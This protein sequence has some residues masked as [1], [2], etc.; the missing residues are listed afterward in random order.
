MRLA[1]RLVC[2]KVV[3]DQGVAPVR[4]LGRTSMASSGPAARSRRAVPPAAICGTR[5]GGSSGPAAKARTGSTRTTRGR[6]GIGSAALLQHEGF[7]D[8]R[9]VPAHEDLP[10]RIA[11]AGRL[12]GPAPPREENDITRLFAVPYDTQTEPSFTVSPLGQWACAPLHQQRRAYR[13]GELQDHCKEQLDETGMVWEP[14][15]EAWESKLAVLSSYRRAHGHLRRGGAGATS[16]CPF[17]QLRANLCGK[18]GLGKDLRRAEHRAAQLTAVDPD[19]NYPWALDWQRHYAVLRD[20]VDADGTL[21]DPP[22]RALRGPGRVAGAASP[23]LDAAV[24]R[25][26]TATLHARIK[27]V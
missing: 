14:G 21:P 23:R 18:G 20:L 10:A 19:W 16:W 27:P 11:V 4:L 15:D 8:D 3:V 13:A 17:G 12:P 22:R 1:P 6:D 25:A 5:T 26:V 9:R 7:S 24:R 2:D